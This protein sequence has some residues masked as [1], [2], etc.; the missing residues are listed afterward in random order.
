MDALVI[1]GGNPLVGRVAISGAKNAALPLMAASLLTDEPVTF[2]R[3]P[4][5]ADV[6]TLAKILSQFGASVAFDAANHTLTLHTPAITSDQ[7]PYD[8]VR[9]MRASFFVMGP[10]LAR[11]GTAKISLPG[12]CAIGTRPV[13]LHIHALE[14]LG[15]E[16]TLEEGYVRAVAPNGLT[17]AEITFEKVS[18]GA[19]E[20]AMMAATLAQG[21]TR[22][23]NAA[24]EPEIADL[25]ACLNAMGAKITGIGTDCIEI[26][27]VARLHGAT[28]EVVADRIEA[29]SFAVAAAITAGDVL[30]EGVKPQLLGAV[31]EKLE[32]A[33]A[34]VIEE[35]DGVRVKR[36]AATPL[37][38]VD[39]STAP[40]PA[41][42]TDMQAQFMAL[43]TVAEGASIIRENIFENRFMHV[44]ELAR[45][46][47]DIA[48]D[49]HSA[50]VRGVK[51]LTSADVMATDLRAS[52]SLVIAAL[53][54][55]GTTTIHRIYH[56]DRGYERLEEKLGA[57]GGRIERQKG[58]KA[59]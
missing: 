21:K 32:E 1:T 51:Q 3:M 40:F 49:G 55:K 31:F 37:T 33:G 23:C 42:P 43:L 22:L 19:T 18:V 58:D 39:V 20:N 57:L 13:D 46:G 38:A 10:L 16:V 2:T 27:G 34:E 50:V 54:A 11:H 48:V 9:T 15:A 24:R 36:N 26:E 35:A 29:G 52:F 56:L 47:A 30:L 45:M 53:A 7:A 5:V 28:H 25:A 6:R 44:P 8:L 12:G 4:M 59:A 14:A 17:G 41:F